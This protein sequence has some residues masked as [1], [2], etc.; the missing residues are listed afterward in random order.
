MRSE[1]PFRRQR[2]QRL[3]DCRKLT[4]PDLDAFT[5]ALRLA[6]SLDGAGIPYAIGGALAF[7]LW[8]DPRG[9]HDVDINLFVSHE[10][11]DR[12]LDVLESAGLQI[13]RQAAHEADQGGDVII[14]WCSG[15][16]VDL[17][18]PSIPFAWEAM[19]RVVRVTSPQGEAA[20]LSAE[21]IAVFKLMFFRPKDLLDVEKLIEVQGDSL[22]L[23]YIRSS[24]VA[25]MGED[26]ERTKALDALI[27][28]SR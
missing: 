22:D 18:T 25:M 6:S 14:G 7:G 3:S 8:G 13:D 17:F 1:I 4:E 11:L 5:L 28:P 16:R 20:Y 24:L 19:S 9:T 2:S 15:M 21:S 12:A 10:E 27:D 26:D 23:Q